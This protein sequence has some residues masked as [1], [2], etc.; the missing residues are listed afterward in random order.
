MRYLY[1]ADGE[2]YAY[3]PGRRDFFRISD[4]SLWAHESHD[5]LVAAVS[6]ELLAHRTSGVY[7]DVVDGE[8]LYYET[9]ERVPGAEPP[10][11][12]PPRGGRL[13]AVRSAPVERIEG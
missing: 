1:K 7:Y 5:W 11:K 9:L 8:P 10:S 4:N 6:G 12:R 13:L 3:A 2:L